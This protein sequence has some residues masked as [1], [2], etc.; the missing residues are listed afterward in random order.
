MTVGASNTSKDNVFPLLCI[1]PHISTIPSRAYNS[2]SLFSFH[3]N[4]LFIPHTTHCCVQ[5]RDTLCI[6]CC[7]CA[8]ACVRARAC[9]CVCTCT[10]VYDT[11]QTLYTHLHAHTH[12][13][14]HGRTH[15]CTHARTHTYAHTHVQTQWTC[16]L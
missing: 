12:A 8:C 7:V 3:V 5:A 15:A 13:H 1:I 6:R 10:Y 16:E 14:M 9:V 4:F 11:L 2:I